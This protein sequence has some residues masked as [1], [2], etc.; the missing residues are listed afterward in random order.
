MSGHLSYDS[1]VKEHAL[2]VVVV[3]LVCDLLLSVCVSF[4]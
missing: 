3:V 2:I 1:T 4:P